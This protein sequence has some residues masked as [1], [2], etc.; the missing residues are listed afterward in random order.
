MRMFN[1]FN[2]LLNPQK[3]LPATENEPPGHLIARLPLKPALAPPP[4]PLKPALK[5]K[6]D[7]IRWLI[8]RDIPEVLAIERE[9]FEYAWSEN[10]LL[11]Y[12]RQSNCIGMVA[13]YNHRIVGFMVYELCKNELHIQ[14]F[15]VD[16]EFRRQTVGT[17]MV[18]KLVDKLIQQRRQRIIVEVR[19]TNLTAQLFFKKQGFKA[20][21]VLHNHYDETAEDAYVM[22]FTLDEENAACFAAI[23]EN[24][25]DT[26]GAFVPHNR[27]T[28][29]YAD[30]D[31]A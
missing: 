8:R 31:A 21:F 5:L 9:S 23:P 15:A 10:D 1:P 27:I 6:Y 3:T 2:L 30:V 24:A 19:E 11:C 18:E 14:N 28:E 26:N 7:E 29:Y 25:C 22:R 13:E 12:L 17:Q 20:V 4:V 16:S